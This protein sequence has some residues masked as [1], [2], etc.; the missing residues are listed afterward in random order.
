MMHRRVIE[1]Y[2]IPAVI[3]NIGITIGVFM[4]E[5]VFGCLTLTAAM[6]AGYFAARGKRMTYVYSTIASVLC[7][8]EAYANQLYGT[9]LCFWFI[10][11][12]IS[13]YAA[14]N[15][16]VNLRRDSK[17][18]LRNFKPKHITIL[19]PVCAACS[20][21]LSFLLSRIPGQNTPIYDGIANSV[22]L[23]GVVLLTMRHR[24]SWFFL[25]G[26]NVISIMIWSTILSAGDARAI[27][28]LIAYCGVLATNIYGI[29]NW[30]KIKYLN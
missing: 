6:L 20:A 21:L 19:V 28:M 24:E 22:M 15:W 9:A 7:G 18:K 8:Y 26:S 3:A 2:V 27:V 23:C 5:L 12:P 14:I 4:N 17:M 13:I 10:F 1:N 11:I 29:I 30:N 25:I 16:T